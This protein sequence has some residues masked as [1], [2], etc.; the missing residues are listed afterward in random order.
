[1]LLI[2][3]SGLRYWLAS[4]RP[5]LDVV[6]VE[7][8]GWLKAGARP[9]CLLIGGGAPPSSPFAEDEQEGNMWSLVRI[10]CTCSA[11]LLD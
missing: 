4:P 8:G 5:L 11:Y 7:D 10:K 3:I 2:L 6:D 9:R 1:M